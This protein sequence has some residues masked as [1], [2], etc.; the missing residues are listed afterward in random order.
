VALFQG[1]NG[2]RVVRTKDGKVTRDLDYSNSDMWGAATNPVG[3]VVIASSASGSIALWEVGTTDPAVSIDA[4]PSGVVDES[5]PLTFSFSSNEPDAAFECS[6]DGAAFASCSSP[7][8]F[9]GSADEGQ[10]TFQARATDADGRTGTSELRSYT[11]S[12]G[13]P[14][15]TITSGP[16]EGSTI[17]ATS[18]SFSFSASEGGATFE[19]S[20]DGAPF[21][22]C[23]SPRVLTGLA[24]GTH[25]FRVQAKDG[26]G[27]VDASPAQRTFKVA[28]AAP[29]AG[30]ACA[31]AKAKLA[32]AKAKLRKAKDSGNKGKIKKAKAKVRKAKAKV[33]K[34]C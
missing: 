30:K 25:T 22:A 8:T 16:A 5:T 34:A 23:T 28:P 4:G 7:A 6:W 21:T 11:V 17:A 24:A 2:A 29:P 32:K 20:L 12:D 33:K 26:I 14:E 3:D 10:H 9:S 27:N 18:A 13:P 31:K 15:T 1:N 19:C